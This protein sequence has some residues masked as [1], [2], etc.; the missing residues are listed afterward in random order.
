MSTGNTEK[1][2]AQYVTDEKPQI[3]TKTMA[4]TTRAYAKHSRR[5]MG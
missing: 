5:P 4:T 2:G 1:A 3:P